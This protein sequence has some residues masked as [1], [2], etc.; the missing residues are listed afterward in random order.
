MWGQYHALRTSDTFTSLWA[1]L[2]KEAGIKLL[3]TLY[4][5]LTDLIFKEMIKLYFPVE[6][7]P[8]SSKAAASVNIYEE[9]NAVRYVAGFVCRAVRKEI[10]RCASPLK[11]QLLLSTWELL[12]DQDIDTDSSDSCDEDSNTPSRHCKESSRDWIKAVDRGGLLHVTDDT[13]LTFSY[14]EA[15][16]QR[17]LTISNMKVISEVNLKQL[18]DV[19]IADE[20]VQFQWCIVSTDMSEEVASELLR[21]IVSMW[22]TIRGHS[23]SKC[24]M[25]MYKQ[26]EK[27]ITGRSK[28]LRKELFT[29]KVQ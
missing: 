24:Y 20:E 18:V 29:S 9:A 14:M 15:A 3:P 12:E 13:Y 17:H 27:K 5:H 11:Q 26:Q 10:N 23:F 6:A 16:V 7:Q 2:L 25:E 22:V 4:Q 1:L 28:G 8:S 19:V 21:R